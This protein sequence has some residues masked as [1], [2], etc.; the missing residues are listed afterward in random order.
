M[1]RL[2]KR[3]KPIIF[4][5]Q[6]IMNNRDA[7]FLARKK[8]YQKLFAFSLRYSEKNTDI[9]RLKMQILANSSLTTHNLY[10]QQTL[11]FSR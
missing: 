1:V 5:A 3:I 9:C 8:I 7:H 2:Y 10:E 4:A 11:Y 6:A